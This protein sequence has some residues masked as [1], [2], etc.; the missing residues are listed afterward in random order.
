MKQFEALG[1]DIVTARTHYVPRM[2]KVVT[3]PLDAIMAIE[4]EVPEID[5]AAGW[6][7][8]SAGLVW[9]GRNIDRAGML[10]VTG[11]FAD[12]AGLRVVEGR[13]V[14]DL[15]TRRYCVIGAFVARTMREGGTEQVL[16]QRV[17]LGEQLWTVVGVLAPT[18]VSR[19]NHAPDRSVF[20]PM[21]AALLY[22]DRAAVGDV[23]ART[24]PGVATEDGARALLQHL[25]TS[26]EGIAVRVHTAEQLIA[27]MRHQARLFAV[28]LATVGGIALIVGGVGIMNVMLISVSE[29]RGEIGLRMAV[30]AR[31]RDIRRHFVLEAMLL[32]T[33]GGLLGI[34]LGVVAAWAICVY[35]E[36]PF[37]VSLQGVAVGVGVSTAVGLLF[38]VH[39]ALQAAR[40]DP[41]AALRS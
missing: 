30:G 21:R 7:E 22:T 23:I 36:W 28:L 10:A 24:R 16:G 41:I 33:T 8:T 14:S 3:F 15:D 27:G 6:N 20:L 32:C 31:R 17:R 12:V 18:T 40:L 25:S 13:F 1:T 9:R 19:F 26:A 29:R 37:S 5:R 39:P 2:G 11:G 38:G 35:S 34:G 4:S